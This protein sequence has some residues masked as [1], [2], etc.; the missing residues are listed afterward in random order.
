MS[1]PSVAAVTN[2]HRA[3]LFLSSSLSFAVV[4]LFAI[5]VRAALWPVVAVHLKMSLTLEFSGKS[6]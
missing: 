6:Q 3:V 2:Q 4:D 1:Q 5:S